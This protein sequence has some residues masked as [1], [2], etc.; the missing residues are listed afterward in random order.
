MKYFN[1]NLCFSVALL[2]T[3]GCNYNEAIYKNYKNHIGETSFKSDID[4]SNFKFCDSTKIVHS[5]SKISYK[6]GTKALEDEIES[7]FRLDKKNKKFTGYIFLRFAVN[8]NNET[9]RY[10][11]QVFDE[12]FNKISFPTELKKDIIKIMKDLKGWESV[13]NEGVFYDGY[14]FIVIK[15][16]NGKFIK[17]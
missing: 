17:S 4:D 12:D 16:V 13:N 9:G 7:K 14:T 6:G 11:W 3:V 10:R 2:L 1:L 8:C 15:I 5:R